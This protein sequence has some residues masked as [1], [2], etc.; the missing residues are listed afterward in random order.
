MADRDALGGTGG[1]RREH[2]I[3]GGVH[4]QGRQPV[5]V[6][7][8][9]RGPPGHVQIVDTQ[10][11]AR[12]GPGHGVGATSQHTHRRHRVQHGEPLDRIGRIHWHIRS[13]GLDQGPPRHHQLQRPTHRHTHG[14]L[15][16]HALLDQ[17]PRQPR[18]PLIKL[19]IRHLAGTVDD[20]HR[21]RVGRYRR[22]QQLRRQPHR[23]FNASTRP[24]REHQVTL[25][26]I[27]QVDVTHHD[28]RIR[29]HRLDHPSQPDDQ[30][31]DGGPVKEIRGVAHH[32]GRHRRGRIV[33]R[34]LTELE[35]Q[36]ELGGAGQCR[37]RLNAE[38]VE[39]QHI[40]AHVV[41]EGH[42]HLKQRMMCRRA[43]G[44]ELLDQALERNILI[45]VGIQRLPAHL[46]E[47]IA[48]PVRRIDTHPQHPC[49]DEEPDQIVERLI[50]PPGDRR[51][52]HHV[53]A[54][55]NPVQQ[56]RHDRLQ[57]H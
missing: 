17:H 30:P 19:A 8:R 40:G 50:Q 26:A 22:S 37:Q 51:A 47:H 23:R 42:E 11:W 31:L 3:G 35:V 36:V 4:A 27:E 15:R 21:A 2:H 25:T 41:L 20:R 6:G 52:H 49:V 29:H 7:N 18:R 56:H 54:D 33:G 55:A 53:L 38:R 16:T 14:A 44:I 10:H 13:A 9:I 28:R 46:L 43:H 5:G 57:H 39:R 45:A 24:L 12:P 32:P 1:P 34:H 48:E